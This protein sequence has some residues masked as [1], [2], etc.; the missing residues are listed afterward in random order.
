M[1]DPIPLQVL[2]LDM[3]CC[4]LEGVSN[5][6]GRVKATPSVW[7]IFRRVWTS[8]Q[9]NR[10][11]HGPQPLCVECGD[12][13]AHRIDFFRDP[14]LRRTAI[15]IGEAMWTALPFRQRLNRCSPSL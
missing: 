14:Q 12:L 6:L 1:L 11:I 8:V 5:P 15:N 10:Y 7:S 13:A 9:V 2:F 3:R 4:D